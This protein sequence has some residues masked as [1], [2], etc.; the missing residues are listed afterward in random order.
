VDA[1]S[2]ELEQTRARLLNAEDQIGKLRQELAASA[3]TNAGSLARIE[4]ARSLLAQNHEMFGRERAEHATERER[5][6]ERTKQTSHQRF[7]VLG[8]TFRKVG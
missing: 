5:L 7:R 4:D 1:A 3:A 2:R 8:T 6:E